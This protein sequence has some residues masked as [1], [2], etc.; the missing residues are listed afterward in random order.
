MSHKH[1]S[2]AVTQ[3]SDT[4]AL[5]KEEEMFPKLSSVVQ[6]SCTRES[7]GLRAEGHS[8]YTQVQSDERNSALRPL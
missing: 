7:G 6:V 4:C 8:E 5:R 2:V 1:L 3:R